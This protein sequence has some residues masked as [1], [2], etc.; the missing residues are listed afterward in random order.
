MTTD[1]PRRD[2]LIGQVVGGRYEIIRR[3]GRGAMGTIYEARH[4]KLKRSF[5]LKT[6]VAHLADDPEALAR[7]QREADAV[8]QLRDFGVSKIRG[9][10][11]HTSGDRV[12][13][14]PAYM[15]PEQAEGRTDLTSPAA[16]VWAVGAMLFEAATGKEPFSAAGA[17]SIL[18]RIVHGDPEPL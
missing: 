6:L 3:I 7:F 5:A 9:D 14:T 2:P 1:A 16:D 10:G 15:A 8:A 11:P 17:M 12:I 18:Y 13:G 4:K